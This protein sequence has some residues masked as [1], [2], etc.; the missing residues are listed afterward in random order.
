MPNVPNAKYLADLAHQ[1]PKKPLE[2]PQQ[3]WH[4]LCHFATSKAYFIIL[5]HH[6]TTF[7]LS[8]VLSFNSIH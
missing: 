5:P 6:F 7:H 3:L 4:N 8:D 1:T 2:H